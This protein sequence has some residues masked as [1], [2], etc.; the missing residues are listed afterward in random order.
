MEQLKKYLEN[1]SLDELLKI[2]S[3][4]ESITFDNDSIVRK[5]ISDYELSNNFHTGLISLRSALLTEI[6]KRLIHL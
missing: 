1:L 3:M 2:S 5:L 4:S 6:T